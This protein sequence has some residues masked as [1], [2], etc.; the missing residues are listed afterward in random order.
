MNEEM[1]RAEASGD[2]VQEEQFPEGGQ[3]FDLSADDILN[4]VWES[5]EDAYEFYRRRVSRSE[6]DRC[7]KDHNN[8]MHAYGIE[9]SKLLGYMAGMSR[10]YSFLGF[11]KK[12]AYNYANMMR[13]SRIADDDTNAT[14]VYLEGKVAA[15][16]MYVARYNLAKDERLGNMVWVDGHSRSDFQCF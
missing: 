2:E 16:P 11:L 4:Q 9:T 3:G 1:N 12:D 14:L 8:R 5:V 7:G 10:G 15:N 13:R 6:N